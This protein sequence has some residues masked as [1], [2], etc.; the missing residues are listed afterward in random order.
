M[1]Q[2]VYIKEN[3]RWEIMDTSDYFVEPE[4]T[5]HEYKFETEVDARGVY[6]HHVLQKTDGFSLEYIKIE[7]E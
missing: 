3:D 4:N 6:V 2:I 5:F 7:Q 1:F